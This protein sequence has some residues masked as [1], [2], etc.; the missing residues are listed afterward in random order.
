MLT[1]TMPRVNVLV[2]VDVLGNLD[3]AREV[4]LLEPALFGKR[5]SGLSVGR[6]AG[7]DE[8][9]RHGECE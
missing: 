3:D 4:G 5:R 6:Q 7:R 8:S 1:V 2:A 9:H